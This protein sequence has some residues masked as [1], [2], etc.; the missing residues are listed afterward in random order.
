[1]VTALP[2]GTEQSFDKE[3][4]SM[5]A[6]KKISLGLA[7]CS[8]LATSEAMALTISPSDVTSVQNLY[9][10]ASLTINNTSNMNVWSGASQL[11]INGMGNNIYEFCVEL[12]VNG[13]Y[14]SYDVT[15]LSGHFSTLQQ[16]RIGALLSNAMPLLETAINEYQ[17]VYGPISTHLNNPAWQT[18]LDYSSA[19]QLD[20]WEIVEE[21]NPALS[22]VNGKIRLQT[23]QPATVQTRNNLAVSFLSRVN[24]GSWVNQGNYQIYY[25]SSRQQDQL[26]VQKNDGSLR[27]LPEPGSLLLLA[28]GFGVMSLVTKKRPVADNITA[29]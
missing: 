27:K 26:L 24:D 19:I 18:I 17:S 23:G 5:H 4:T 28:A 7:F 29:I 21:T 2:D 3:I 9:M 8:S 10:P 14:R 13:I 12:F 15:P 11:N 16:D 25:A 20:I 6:L 1:M 22:M